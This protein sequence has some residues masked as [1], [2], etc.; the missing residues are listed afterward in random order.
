MFNEVKEPQAAGLKIAQ[1]ANFV[2]KS[3]R[4]KKMQDEEASIVER[5]MP[6]SWFRDIYDVAAF[7]YDTIMGDSVNYLTLWLKNFAQSPLRELRSFAYGIQMG[8][9]A[10]QNAVA[11]DTSNGI[12]EGYV[13]KMK[14]VK[15]TMYGRV[16]LGLLKRKMVFSDLCFN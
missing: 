7:F 5:L 3:I 6:F 10:V 9:K 8:L 13:N 4:K 1:I 12:V 14:A 15:R 2:D 11:M 16:S